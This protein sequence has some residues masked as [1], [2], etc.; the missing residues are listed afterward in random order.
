MATNK[1]RRENRS[2]ISLT[3]DILRHMLRFRRLQSQSEADNL[4]VSEAFD[5][6]L[7]LDLDMDDD[8]EEEEEEE[9]EEMDSHEESSG[10]EGSANPRDC[11]I[12]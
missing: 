11:F 6:D 2:H 8:D 7:D 5:E 4:H 9:E 1:R 10:S 12:S 3:P